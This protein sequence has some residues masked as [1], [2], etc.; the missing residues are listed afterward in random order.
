MND[1]R[2]VPSELTAQMRVMTDNLIGNIEHMLEEFGINWRIL[3]Y[4]VG[5]ATSTVYQIK[6]GRANAGTAMAVQLA[7][8]FEVSPEYL[9]LDKE[10]FLKVR[11]REIPKQKKS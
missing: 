9:F 7:R 2:I 11:N 3:S 5:L 10:L 8:H 1:R 6:N 4:E